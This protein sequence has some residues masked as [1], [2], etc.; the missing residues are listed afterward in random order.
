VSLIDQ[1][2]RGFL[3]RRDVVGDL[4]RVTDSVE[5]RYE[6]A[7]YLIERDPG[8]IVQ[9]E[10]VAGS[11]MPVVANVLGSL[12]RIAECLGVERSGIQSAITRAARTH[13]LR[14]GGWPVHHCRRHHR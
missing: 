5:L 3:E 10:A 12:D 2:L 4:E 1:S 6:L 11:T 13:L 8:P 7:A 9:F 14:S